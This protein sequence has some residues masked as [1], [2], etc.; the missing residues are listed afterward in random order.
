MKKIFFGLTLLTVLGAVRSFAGEEYQAGL[1]FPNG[2]IYL[3]EG[4]LEHRGIYPNDGRSL[5]RDEILNQRQLKF[6]NDM[7]VAFC[8]TD[9]GFD[10]AVSEIS[11]NE[12]YKILTLTRSQEKKNS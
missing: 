7:P 5:S 9:E 6:Q 8:S 3:Y 12:R 1:C 2:N 10:A 4:N 11:G